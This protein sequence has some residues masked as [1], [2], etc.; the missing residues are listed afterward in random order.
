MLGDETDRLNPLSV[1]APTASCFDARA[2]AFYLMK[3]DYRLVIRTAKP[4]LSRMMRHVNG[5]Y[6]QLYNRCQGT[7]TGNLFRGR[8]KAAVVDRNARFPNV[9]RHGDLNRV[10][11]GS[12]NAPSRWPLSSYLAHT[13]S[14]GAPDWLD[15]RAS[16]AKFW[17][18][19]RQPSTKRAKRR[20]FLPH[21]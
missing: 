11:A 6:T 18:G 14:F 17:V 5:V 16:T 9:C 10:W 1:F 8:F 19:R 2:P 21:L 15:T 4:D 13:G 12:V 7:T 20:D 3:N